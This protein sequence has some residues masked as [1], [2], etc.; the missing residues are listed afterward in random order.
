MES[1]FQKIIR[2]TGKKPIECKCN[3][4][5]SQC[6]FPCI[7]TP[8]DMVK[9]IGAG[10][11]NR[12]GIVNWDIARIFGVHDSDIEMISP[13]HDKEK[14]SCTFF[15]NGLCELHE[16]GIK[17]TEG[18]LS[19]HSI[20]LKGFDFKKSISWAVAKEWLNISRADFELLIQKHI[21]Q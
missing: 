5:K 3:T 7:G 15:T 10:Y 19:H 12:V 6:K 18:K 1:T 2:K 4:C 9:I 14:G 16:K 11:S 20:E 17:P 13:L 8:E 21:K